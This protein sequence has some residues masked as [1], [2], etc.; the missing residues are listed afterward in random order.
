[1]KTLK[2]LF[3]RRQ[4]TLNRRD[5]SRKERK[6]GTFKPL[7]SPEDHTTHGFPVPQSVGEA[8]FS[9]RAQALLAQA[10]AGGNP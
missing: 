7:Q 10:R 4:K 8:P 6:D 2:P 3:S 9:P 1:M 5:R